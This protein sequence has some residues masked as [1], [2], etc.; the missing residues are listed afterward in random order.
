MLTRFTW[1]ARYAVVILCVFPLFL[2]TEIFTKLCMQTGIF[3]C[4][5]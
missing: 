2:P 4:F 1:E 5:T 3:V